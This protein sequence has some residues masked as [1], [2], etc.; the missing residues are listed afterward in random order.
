MHPWLLVL[1]LAS[2]ACSELGGSGESVRTPAVARSGS[3]AGESRDE[4]GEDG[5]DDDDD[6]ERDDDDVEP[7]ASAPV[8]EYESERVAVSAENASPT[9]LDLDAD[10]KPE[11]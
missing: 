7:N 8:L 4:S 5:D 9:S 1:L 2:M 6:D 10:G 11:T 3:A